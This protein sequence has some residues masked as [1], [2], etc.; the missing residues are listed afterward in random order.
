MSPYDT[1]NFKKRPSK[2]IL[3]CAILIALTGVRV[4]QA[5]DTGTDSKD[6][7]AGSLWDR[8]WVSGQINSITQYHPSFHSAYSGENSMDASAQWASSRVLTLFTGFQV[9]PTTDV[10]LDVESAGGTG[11]S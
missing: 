3:A 1:S 9:S 2:V 6:T 5:Q 7:N 4:L 11:L 8:V 10:I